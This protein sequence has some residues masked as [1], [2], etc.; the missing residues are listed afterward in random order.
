LAALTPLPFTVAGT[1]L[2]GMADLW[3]DFRRQRPAA[4][5]S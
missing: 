5:D 4:D 1:A 2:L 3:V